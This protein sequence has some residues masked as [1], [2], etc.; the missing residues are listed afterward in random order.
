MIFFT[1]DLH[2]GHEN[3]IRHCNRP[4]AS[5]DEMDAALTRNWNAVVGEKDE[6]YILGDFTMRPAV[7]AHRCLTR[8]NGHKYLISGNHDRF[9]KGFTPYMSDFVWV[10]DYYVLSAGGKWLVLFHFPILEWYQFHRGAIH[11]YG[12]VHNSKISAERLAALTGPAF[13]VG[14]DVNSF[15]P[16]SIDEIFQ[17]AARMR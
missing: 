4:F 5:A 15:T 17:R 3:I 12:H 1:S 9:L 6:I 2:F 16:V 14:A 13:N 7:E 8:L 10:K 11:L